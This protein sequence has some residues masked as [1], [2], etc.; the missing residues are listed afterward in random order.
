M[1]PTVTSVQRCRE[2]K[3]KLYE[4]TLVMHQQTVGPINVVSPVALLAILPASDE[5]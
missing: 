2:P 5:Y 1:I 3:V 4:S